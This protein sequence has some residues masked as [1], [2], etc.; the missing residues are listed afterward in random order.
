MKTL[1]ELREQAV[2]DVEAK[3]IARALKLSRGNKST[4]SKILDVDYKTLLT[5]IKQYNIS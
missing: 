4:A 3:A 5:K 2:A 1:R